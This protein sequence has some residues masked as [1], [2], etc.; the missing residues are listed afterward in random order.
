VK[1]QVEVKSTM[2]AAMRARATEIAIEEQA[3]TRTFVTAGRRTRE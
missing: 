2:A 3:I 1:D